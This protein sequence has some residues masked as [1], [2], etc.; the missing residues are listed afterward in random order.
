MSTVVAPIA[1][2]AARRARIVRRFASADAKSPET[3]R[4]LEE[5]GLSGGHAVRQM[6]KDGVLKQVSGGRL[7]LD[8]AANA[9]FYR[10]ARLYVAITFGLGVTAA[11]VLLLTR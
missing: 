2:V 5:L 10:R 1:A 9:E 4:S 6:I 3:A 11:L 7:W 8:E